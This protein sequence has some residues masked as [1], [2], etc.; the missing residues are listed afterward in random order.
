MCAIH[1]KNLKETLIE[2]YCKIMRKFIKNLSLL[3]VVASL[4]FMMSCN[5][6]EETPDVPIVSVTPNDLLDGTNEVEAGGTISFV[7]DVDAPGGFNTLNGD[8]F[9][10]GTLA[11][12]TVIGKTPGT[13]P[14]SY[15]S[16][17]FRFEY[18]N[19]DVGV[20]F[21]YVFQAVD[22]TGQVSNEIT[23]SV[24][25]T[26]P[27]ARS[28]STVLLAAPL[29][30]KA[31]QSFFSVATGTK[32]SP[33]EVTGTQAAISPTIDFGYYYG[34]NNKA[35]I[36]SPAGFVNTAFAGQVEG[37]N[38]K[39]ETVIKATTLGSTEFNEVSTWADIDAEFEAGTD[40]EGII[41][42]LVAG[43]VVAFETVG[44]VKGLILVNS[45]VDG[46]GDGQ[47]DGESD[48]ISIDVLAQLSA[49]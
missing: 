12:D 19:E 16:G 38:T 10:D 9:A 37:W 43:D 39:N 27:E 24:E 33:S 29:G 8:F 15:T 35:S 41:T 20:L 28:Y 44:G 21:T 46:N 30:N 18:D 47:Y 6:D 11:K 7:I 36:A 48:S 13:S 4:G 26:S 31:A 14:L 17:Q 5:E 23:I 45:I 49:L 34:T 40:E 2:S 42:Q 25:V 32:Y 1:V 22:E 3:A